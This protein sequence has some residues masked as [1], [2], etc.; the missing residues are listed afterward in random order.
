MQ[1]FPPAAEPAAFAAGEGVLFWY[2]AEHVARAENSRRYRMDNRLQQLPAAR[3]YV[4][5]RLTN[6]A[7]A[8]I[9][10]VLCVRPFVDRVMR[11]EL[12]R[13]R[14]RG[15]A[16]W[17]D[18]DDLLFQGAPADFPGAG[19]LWQR[20]RWKRR[21]PVYASG[22]DAFDAF[23]CSTP[24]IAEAL[25]RLR[26]GAPVH[27][28]ENVPNSAWIEQG[29]AAYGHLAWKPGAP[30]VLR[31][32][33]GSPSHDEDFATV[34]ATLARLLHEVPELELE[35]VGYLNFHPQ[36]FPAAR[37]RHRPKVPYAQLPELLLPT[38]LNLVPK[39]PTP[40]SRARSNIKE[41]EALA[42]DVPSVVGGASELEAGIRAALERGR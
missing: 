36:K 27:L 26:P 34:E 42:F 23:T 21:L 10:L 16:A 29:W 24:P 28:V 5:R 37:V 41:L 7:L 17:A 2:G 35:V 30:R 8:G 3:S 18:Y 4:G 20:L 9:R 25:A 15:L 32:L 1:V 38:W 12:E 22:L 39:A 40:Y 13:L 6:A 31:Y 33:P 19:R 11:R 14:A